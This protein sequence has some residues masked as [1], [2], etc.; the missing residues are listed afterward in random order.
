MPVFVLLP[1]LLPVVLLL[2]I[3]LMLVEALSSGRAC[4][5]GFRC[6]LGFLPSCDSDSGIG[7]SD[8]EHSTVHLSTSGAVM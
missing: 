7:K 8:T 1:V 3:G 4:D 6:L 5:C 2:A